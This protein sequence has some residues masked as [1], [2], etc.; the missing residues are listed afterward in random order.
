MGDGLMRKFHATEH[1]WSSN[2]G[3]EAE[4]EQKGF[5]IH[6][7]LSTLRKGRLEPRIRKSCILTVLGLAAVPNAVSPSS[8][9]L[10]IKIQEEHLVCTQIEYSV[11][12]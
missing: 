3:S 10:G 8:P 2:S 5:E 11:Q 9:L 4:W 1:I 7:R 6:M 12:Q